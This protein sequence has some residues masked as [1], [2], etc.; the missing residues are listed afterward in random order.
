MK[1]SAVFSFV[2]C[3]VYKTPTS[4]T[5]HHCAFCYY[6]QMSQ[7]ARPGD[8]LAYCPWGQKIN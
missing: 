4:D 7:P 5:I 1:G 8:N 3:L 2:G 6:R